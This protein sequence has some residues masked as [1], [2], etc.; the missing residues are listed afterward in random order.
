MV[1]VTLVV[2]LVN[3]TGTESVVAMIDSIFPQADIE[4][5]SSIWLS[6]ENTYEG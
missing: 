2:L 5:K 4:K 3:D 1:V 6:E